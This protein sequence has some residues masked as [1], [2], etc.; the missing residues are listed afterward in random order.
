MKIRGIFSLQ[1]FRSQCHRGIIYPSFNDPV[2][3]QPHKLKSNWLQLIARLFP[4]L[5][6]KYYDWCVNERIVEN[7]FVF[8]HL[9]LDKGSRILDLGCHS[10]RI[11]LQL[12]NLGYKVVGIDFLD[13]GFTHPNFE[14]HKEDL[15]ESNFQSESFDGV[16]A[17]STVEHA[18]FCAYSVEERKRGNDDILLV[19]EITRVLKKGGQFIITVPF[20][21]KA[22]TRTQKVYDTQSLC[23]LLRA[24]TI[25]TES[26]YRCVERK[27]WFEVDKKWFEQHTP[28]D[29]HVVGVALL[30]CIRK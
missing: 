3:Y 29:R 20:G 19:N 24:Y 5:A 2:S 6:I 13:Y 25:E 10:S 11:S 28:R 30:S 7:P 16:L 14:F 22:R 18:G 8:M 1:R 23:S 15:L 21:A 26:Y 9:K 12:A 4:A 17:I 27:Y